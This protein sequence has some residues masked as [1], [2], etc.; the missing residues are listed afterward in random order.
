MKHKFFIFSPVKPSEMNWKKLYPA[1][2]SDDSRGCNEVKFADVGCGYGGLL[3]TLKCGIS[4]V[5]WY[6]FYIFYSLF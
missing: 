4:L 3:G 5:Y 6:Y 1:F 2:Y